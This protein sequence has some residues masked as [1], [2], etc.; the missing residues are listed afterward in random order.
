MYTNIT[1][2]IHF[3]CQGDLHYSIPS[4]ATVTGYIWVQCSD[5]IRSW[6]S[7]LEKEDTV[8]C[9]SHFRNLT[10]HWSK[11]FTE[12]QNLCTDV[13]LRS[14]TWFRF[15][16]VHHQWTKESVLLHTDRRTAQGYWGQLGKLEKS[17]LLDFSNF[18]GRDSITRTVTGRLGNRTGAFWV[19]ELF[20]LTF[21]KDID[22]FS[23]SISFAVPDLRSFWDKFSRKEYHDTTWTILTLFSFFSYIFA[24]V[25]GIV[26]HFPFLNLAQSPFH[27]KI[28]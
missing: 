13:R 10:Q 27:K 20:F 17:S 26:L 21:S 5:K 25:L 14:Y 22:W 4:Q 6:K 28:I 19:L 12:W 15:H 16:F 7:V 2:Q 24:F 8:I 11:E 23:F 1:F 3:C 18:Y 9:I